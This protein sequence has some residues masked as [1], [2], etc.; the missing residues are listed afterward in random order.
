[1]SSDNNTF[2]CGY[3]YV[4]DNPKK[5][6]SRGHLNYAVK[7]HM[8]YI[9]C[10]EPFEHPTA[11]FLNLPY[12]DLPSVPY[13]KNLSRYCSSKDF[14]H[15]KY[16]DRIK[17]EAF[18]KLATIWTSKVFLFAEL[19]KHVNSEFI[20]W[21]D[22]VKNILMD[23]IVRHEC[24]DRVVVSGRTYNWPRQ[25]FKKLYTL[26]DTMFNAA[27]RAQVIRIPTAMLD[28]FIS[29]YISCLEHVDANF[30]VYDEEIVLAY[31]CSTH[32]NLFV[33]L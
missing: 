1:M 26:H 5:T 31:M 27:V 32:P 23:S 16:G 11:K 10:E 24:C 15:T 8:D 9:F 25:P 29:V 2:F 20:T 3:W 4:A 30:E 18:L 17:S 19:A 13:I 14:V 22:M 12:S 28:D 33:R 6:A 21:V 7:K